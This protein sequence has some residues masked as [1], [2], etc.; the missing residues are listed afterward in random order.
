M[1]VDEAVAHRWLWA[2]E[3]LTVG[4]ANGVFDLVHP[5]H[6]SLVRRAALTCDRLIVAINSDESV[7]RLKGAGRPVQGELSRAAVVGAIRGVAAVVIF[8]DDTPLELLRALQPDVLVK[9]SDYAEDEV[10]GGEIVKARGGRV[11]LVELTP[12]HSTTQLVALASA[13]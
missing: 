5:G 9:G 2:R 4:V 10:V 1:S 3:R 11:V 7:R 13:R 12:G 8:D 6:V